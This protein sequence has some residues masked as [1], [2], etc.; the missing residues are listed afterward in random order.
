MRRLSTTLVAALLLVIG[1]CA[2]TESGQIAGTV[3]DPT[4]AVGPNANVEAKNIATGNTRKTASNAS[5]VYLL[6]NLV[7]APRPSS[8]P[9]RSTERLRGPFGHPFFRLPLKYMSQGCL[10]YGYLADC[11]VC[12][13]SVYRESDSP[14]PKPHIQP[15]L[16]YC[17]RLRPVRG[18]SKRSRPTNQILRLTVN[19]CNTP[20]ESITLTV[21]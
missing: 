17:N 11:T 10:P 15:N 4:G 18:S 2:Q 8:D 13:H 12:R 3:T 6:P 19:C 21:A 14:V 7:W 5:G 16:N 1:V 9:A 20:Y